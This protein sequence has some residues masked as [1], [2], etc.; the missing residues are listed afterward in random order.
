MKNKVSVVIPSFN[1]AHILPSVIPSYFQEGVGEV[2]VVNDCST[3]NTANV[4]LELKKT[5]PHLILLEN[6]KNIKQ[7]GSKNKGIMHAKYDYIYFGDDDSYITPGTIKNLLDVM[8]QKKCDIAS[9]RA[10]YMLK[11]ETEQDVLKRN[12]VYAENIK[13]ICNTYTMKVNFWIKVKQPVPIPFVNACFLVKKNVAEKIFFSTVFFGNCLREETD[14]LLRAYSKGFINYYVSDA[15]QINL[16]RDVATGGAHGRS[17][18]IYYLQSFC[19][20]AIFVIKNFTTLVRVNKSYK[21]PFIIL[22][23]PLVNF[24]LKKI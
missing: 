8:V 3:D 23:S 19:N 20:N 21:S 12:D 7:T 24:I 9:A 5:Y 2:I 18:A 6:E 4:L 16:P 1:R 10:L 11:G 14:F 15:C 13:D 22:F 17:T